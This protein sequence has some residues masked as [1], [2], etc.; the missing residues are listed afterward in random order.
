MQTYNVIFHQCFWTITSFLIFFVI[1]QYFFQKPVLT[2]INM[3]LKNE[4]ALNNSC[5]KILEEKLFYDQNRIL[6]HKI[7]KEK[8]DGYVIKNLMQEEK[9]WAEEFFQ[10]KLETK[11][12]R[13]S[14]SLDE[15]I[16]LNDIDHLL[17]LLIK[18]LS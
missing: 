18:R 8:I 13:S 10:L 16:D 5:I 2:S 7:N 14:E 9:I 4:E 12:I 6:L 3:R 17:N 15:K 11:M 1:F